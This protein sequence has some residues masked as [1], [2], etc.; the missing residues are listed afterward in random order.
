MKNDI[1]KNP[2][3]NI[4]RE[5]FNFYSKQVLP[6]VKLYSTQN[7]NSFHALDKHTSAVVFRGIDY[8]ISLDKNPVPV[9]FA[10]AFHDMARKNDFFDE[11]HGANAVPNAQKIMQEFRNILT[12]DMQT[13]IIYAIINHTTGKYAP[14]YISSCLWDADRTRMSWVYGYNPTYFNT[15]RAKHVA[16]HPADEYIKFQKQCFPGLFWSYEY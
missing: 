16:S 13:S 7:P 6:R 1:E 12:D 3:I 9:I 15:E 8:A 10:G 2:D 4:M 14:D 5:M 11:N